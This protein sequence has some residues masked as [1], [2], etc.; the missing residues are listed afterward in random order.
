[1]T[2]PQQT[3]T[4]GLLRPYSYGRGYPTLNKTLT[5]AAG[6]A[7]VLSVPGSRMFRLTS[8]RGQF[9]ASSGVANR[10]VFLAFR[11]ADMN[12][13]M[14]APLPTAITAS[15]TVDFCFSIGL[16]FAYTGGDGTQ[17]AAI[18]DTLIERGHVARVSF[19]NAQSGDALANMLWYYDEILIGGD[20]YAPGMATAD[21]PDIE[22]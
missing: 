17:I 10:G 13:Y 7:S 1:M 3:T 4:A 19:T 22:P 6:A 5:P 12:E 18:P 11:D 20:G 2:T 14:R 15:Q 21:R 16:G 9:V 8:V